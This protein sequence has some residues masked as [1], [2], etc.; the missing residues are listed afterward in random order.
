[1]FYLLLSCNEFK[2]LTAKPSKGSDEYNMKYI[3]KY[4]EKE[5]LGY[6]GVSGRIILKVI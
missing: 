2:T 5:N 6:I 1:M 4:E 3:M